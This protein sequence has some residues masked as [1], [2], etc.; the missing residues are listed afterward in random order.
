MQVS[1]EEFHQQVLALCEARGMEEKTLMRQLAQQPSGVQAL[2]DQV[3][4]Q[5]VVELLVEKATFELVDAVVVPET[6]KPQ[7]PE[8]IEEAVVV[9]PVAEVVPVQA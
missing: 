1:V 4:A 6:E 8:M 3:L 5:K 9:D 2:T 7:L